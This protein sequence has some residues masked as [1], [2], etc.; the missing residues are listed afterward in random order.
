MSNNILPPSQGVLRK[1][2]NR[3][4]VQQLAWLHDD[5]YATVLIT[6][7]LDQYGVEALDWHPETIRLEVQSDFGVKLSKNA[8][9]KLMAAIAILTTNYFFRDVARFIQLC[10]VLAGDDFNPTVFDPADSAEM[11]WAITEALLLSPPE[12]NEWFSDE[13]VAYVGAVL[14]NEGFVTAPKVLKFASG[15]AFLEQVKYD[16]TDDPEMFQAIFA[17]QASKAEEVD[18]LVQ[19][20]MNEM[21]GQLEALSLSSGQT[22]NMVQRLRKSMG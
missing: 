16:F 8:L 3:Q 21:I 2:G 22:N 4:K 17:N 10:N 19:E 11:G 1:P 9:D 13:I 15:P 6:M 7:F 18:K 5:S 14:A 12:E 20:N